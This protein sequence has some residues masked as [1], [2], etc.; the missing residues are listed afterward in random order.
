M[1]NC[2]EEVCALPSTVSV[3]DA[4]QGFAAAH[5]SMTHRDKQDKRRG[6]HAWL[7]AQTWK[8]VLPMLEGSGRW[9]VLHAMP[10]LLMV[11][12]LPPLQL[13]QHM[14]L[15]CT[16]F[17]PAANYFLHGAPLWW[18]EGT[19]RNEKSRW[20]HDQICSAL[21]LVLTCNTVL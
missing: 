13:V 21:E 18:E 5:N 20:D 11:A 1:Q 16:V 15:R 14:R 2:H 9:Q 19:P 17:H 4:H 10:Q 7:H 8:C 6:R 12:T 3:E